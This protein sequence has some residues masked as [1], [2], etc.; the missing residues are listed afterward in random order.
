MTTTELA[1]GIARRMLGG[2]YDPL[3]A[4]PELAQLRQRLPG[5]AKGIMDTFVG[6]PAAA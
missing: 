6:V 2:G 5:V 1:K 4:C 3:L